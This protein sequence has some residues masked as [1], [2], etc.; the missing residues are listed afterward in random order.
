ML[1][2]I[3]VIVGSEHLA[4][5]ASAHY[6]DLAAAR[7]EAERCA[8]ELIADWLR[9]G[10][11]DLAGGVVEIIDVNGSLCDL[12]TLEEAMFGTAGRH[13]H[14]HVF[15]TVAHKYVLLTPDLTILDA[16]RAYLA[17]TMT[18][19]AAIS[20]RSIFDVF[21]DNPGDP[22]ADGVRNLSNSFQHVLQHKTQ[23]AMPRL[24]YDIRGRDGVWIERHWQ[25][26]SYPV[27]DHNGEV[28]FIIHQT[29][30]VTPRV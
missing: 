1:F 24:R 21:P 16:N 9:Q 25:P 3:H 23:H 27:L 5:Q 10:R 29:E 20:R 11:L 13:R 4:D 22:A 19:L 12:F 14:R 28:E 15:N 17:A 8:R 30:D 6:A 26:V 7:T 18:D 2:S